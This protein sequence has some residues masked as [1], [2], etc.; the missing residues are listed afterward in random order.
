[1]LTLKIYFFDV[2]GLGRE[3]RAQKSLRTTTTVV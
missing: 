3:G 2:G 1:V